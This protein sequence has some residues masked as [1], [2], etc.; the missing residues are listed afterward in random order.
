MVFPLQQEPFSIITESDQETIQLGK[1][2]GSLLREGD[3]VALVGELGSG[4]TWMTKGIASGLGIDPRTVVT[5]PSFSIVN[6]YPGRVTLYHMDVYRLE[7]FSEVLSA[8]LEEYLHSGGVVVL[9]WANRWPEILPEWTIT[10]GLQILDAER[11]KIIFTSKHPRGAEVIREI[12]RG[13]SRTPMQP[14]N[15]TEVTSD[16]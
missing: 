10:A 12:K 3:V 14:V 2:L 5:S 7:K 16:E 9:E 13:Y 11:R 4:K 1:N 6:E 15:A 8:G